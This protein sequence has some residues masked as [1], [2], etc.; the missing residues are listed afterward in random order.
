MRFLAIITGVLVLVVLVVQGFAMKSSQ[1]IESY[2]YKVVKKFDSFEIRNY[3]AS[4]FTSVKLNTN[5][6]EEASGK[7]FQ[8]LAGYIFGGN[9]TNEEISMTSPV[10]MS[11]EDS[12]T[13]MF[14]VPKGYNKEN[15]PKPN[16]TEIAFTEMPAKTV[17]AITFGGWANSG[18]IEEHQLMLIE[19]LEEEGIA[20]TD[21][22]YFLG[23]NPPFEMVGRR[24]EVIVEL[25]ENY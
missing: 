24:N 6:Y 15:L 18:K 23:Y 5:N 14:L 3:E 20:F 9:E 12:M 1:N 22:F 11:L 8:K 4:L 25:E 2:P 7:G 17:A 19:A 13:M 16:S 10:A 21:V